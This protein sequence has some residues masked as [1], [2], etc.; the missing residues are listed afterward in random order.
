MYRPMT[1]RVTYF[2][3]IILSEYI[4]ISPD[5][6]CGIKGSENFKGSH[7]REKSNLNIKNSFTKNM[8]TIDVSIIVIKLASITPYA[9]L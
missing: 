1:L 7:I 6:E 8:Q 5:K 9:P 2:S 4:N 3:R